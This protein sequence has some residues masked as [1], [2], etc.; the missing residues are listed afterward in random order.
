[1][2]Q[3]DVNN[4]GA[5]PLKRKI[6]CALALVT[7]LSAAGYLLL[8]Q[9]WLKVLQQQRIQ[10]NN[11]IAA[12]QA[13]YQP[14]QRLEYY[15]QQNQHWQHLLSG[16]M[17]EESSA[18]LMVAL[19]NQLR[20]LAR[21]YDIQLQKAEWHDVSTDVFY[22]VIP[23]QLEGHADYH[24]L[25]LFIAELAQF[26]T[27]LTVEQLLLQKYGDTLQFRLILHRYQL[28]VRS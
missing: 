2:L 8:Q 10:Q 23:L 13:S 21:Q 3:L 7:V 15:Q 5:W 6:F 26:D 4:I 20:G 18:I 22:S 9:Y 27:L 19:F 12:Y 11:L 25:A 16:Y 28:V 1:M 24:Q 14:Q 17:T